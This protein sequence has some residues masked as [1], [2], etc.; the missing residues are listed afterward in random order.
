MKL[1]YISADKNR[2]QC[3]FYQLGQDFNLFLQTCKSVETTFWESSLEEPYPPFDVNE[4]DLVAFN[5]HFQVMAHLSREF[6]DSIT[7]P[8]I[9][10]NY[11]TRFYPW[12]SPCPQGNLHDIFQYMI[13]PDTN[14]DTQGDDNVIL[15]PRIVPRFNVQE[16]AVNFN[17]PIISSYGLPSHDKDIIGQLQAI[18]NEFNTAIY[19]MHFPPHSRGGNW[20]IKEFLEVCKSIANPGIIMEFTEE[21]KTKPELLEWLNQS[22]LNIFFYTPN[23]DMATTG[24]FPG[25]IDRAISAQRPIAV[26]DMLCTKYIGGYIPPYPDYSLTEIME[27]GVEAS[28]KM[29]EDGDP[30]KAAKALDSWFERKFNA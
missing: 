11:E 5:Y 22:D 18:Q 2:Q 12:D 24:T 4:F 6:F 1:L 13:V 7:I 25:S 23:R 3:S 28:K 9:L 20:M 27:H 19:R 29:Y 17:C 30:V 16:R 21:F 8:K 14:M 26:L 10:V 15:L